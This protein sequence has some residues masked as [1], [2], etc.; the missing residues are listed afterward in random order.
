MLLVVDTHSTAYHVGEVAG[1]VVVLSLAALV[2][3]RALTR[4]FG[5]R[6]APVSASS[7]SNFSG[8]LVGSTGISPSP[9]E[10]AR[11]PS[12]NG[13][14]VRNL[15]IVAVAVA[16]AA[17]YVASGISRGLLDGGSTGQW[18]TREGVN[19]K[20]GFIAGCSKGVSSRIQTCECVFARLSS[21]PPYN[22]PS[23]FGRLGAEL[24][25]FEQTRAKSTLPAALLSS[26]RSC[27]RS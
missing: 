24:H 3:R 20:A 22:T 15:V 17:T 21:I 14:G 18:S 1:L 10:P 12:T 16:L 26:V 9:R 19:M 11:A 8:L 7:E 13:P 5:S 4:G 27:S 2:I 25:T 23:G 6:A